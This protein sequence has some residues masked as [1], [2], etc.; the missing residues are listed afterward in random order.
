MKNFPLSLNIFESNF[1]LFTGVST[2]N[3]LT[4]L[5]TFKANN[6]LITGSIDFINLPQSLQEFELSNNMLTENFTVS[7]ILN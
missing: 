4:S 3:I 2:S 1:N 5:F 6:N 7:A